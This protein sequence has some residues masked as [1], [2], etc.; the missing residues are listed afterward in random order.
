MKCR[1]Q[2]HIHYEKWNIACYVCKQRMSQSSEISATAANGEQVSPEG[3]QE[4]N[5]KYLP[6]SWYQT[7]ATPYG[8]PWVIPSSSNGKESACNVGDMCLILG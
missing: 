6:S 7:V 1:K 4:G 8:E 2:N 3:I 5:K